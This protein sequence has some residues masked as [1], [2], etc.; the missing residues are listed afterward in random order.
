[1]IQ[2]F[3]AVLD[4]GSGKPVAVFDTVQDGRHFVTGVG[5]GRVHHGDAQLTAAAQRAVAAVGDYAQDQGMR[6]LR[7]VEVATPAAA[8]TR[9]RKA[10]AQADEK[11]GVFFVCRGPDVI[12]AVVVAL[13]VHRD[14]PARAQ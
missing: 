13:N 7:L 12:D 14:A 1:M 8:L 4:D 9:V 2:S 11:D 5:I 3:P 10:L 6:S